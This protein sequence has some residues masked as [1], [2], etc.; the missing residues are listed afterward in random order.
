MRRNFRRVAVPGP[1]KAQSRT[2]SFP[3]P[4]RGWVL[5]ES[6][7]AARPLGA[8][9]LDNWFPTQTGIRLRGGSP[10]YATISTGPVTSMWPYKVG[11]TEKFFAA[12]ANKIFDI[13]TV[14]DADVIPSAAVSSQTSGRYS[15]AQ[16]GTS[17]GDFLYAVNGDD[18]PQLFD[19]TNFYAIDG[20][21][22]TDI[23]YDAES[24]AFTAGLVLT[25]GTSGATATILAV[26]DNGSTGTLRVRETSGTFQDN[27][28]I[29][30]T[31]TGSATSDIPSGPA[32]VYNGITGVTTSNLSF[33]WIFAKRLFF[34]EKGTMK[35]WYLPVGSIS[36]LATSFS[37]SSIFQNGGE[38]LFGGTWS[39]DSGDGL[40]DKCVFVSSTGE[41]AVYQGSDPANASSWGKV[42]VYDVTPPM[43]FNATLRAGGDLVIATE[44]G[45]VPISEAVTKDSAALSL[46]A[47]SRAIEP[48]WKVE[49][50]ARRAK[51]WDILKWPSNNMAVVALPVINSS[52]EAYCFVI[53][54]ETGA[55]CR[56]TGWNT[57]CLGLFNSVGYFGTS[58]GK[59]RQMEA[60]GSD[61][62]MPYTA[63][64]VG[65]WDHLRAPGA[66]KTVHSARTVVTSSADFEVQTSVSADYTVTL[67]SPPNSIADYVTSEWDVGLWDVATWDAGVT[68][69][70]K[71]EWSS[72]GKTGFSIAPQIQVTSGVT[73]TPH[74]NLVAIDVVYEIG[75]VMV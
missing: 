28:T 72:I 58:D 42:G 25:G 8:F 18:S 4:V 17:G 27:E 14:A 61:D 37:L 52:T 66:T 68:L 64:Y 33:V 23:A 70:T 13:T 62:G 35:A 10:K 24:G 63:D 44:G 38:L 20:N 6:L 2:H 50:N 19:G 22:I 46:S 29:T 9:I 67:P 3:A 74:L 43:G 69:T 65:L 51:P 54:L 56:Y 73:P 11:A 26:T 59:I 41:V 75:G 57:E 47:V 40:D 48:A 71:S 16:I 31:S 7:A 45:M 55:W 30:D 32:A 12:D 1:A 39:L 36:G 15:T 21:D 5:N 34:V 60:G 53:N 49:V